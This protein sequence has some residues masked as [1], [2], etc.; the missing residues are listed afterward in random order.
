MLD[1][2]FNKTILILEDN[3]RVVSML[4]DKLYKLEGEQPYELSV[5]VL[6]NHLQVENYINNNPG[7]DFD[8][9]LLDR[10]CKLGGSFHVLDIE[11]FGGKKIISISSVLEY[12][13]QAQSRGVSTAVLKDLANIKDFTDSVVKEVA[14]RI[15]ELPS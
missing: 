11:R 10:D 8:I 6:T 1:M 3:L 4:L 12:N 9:A 2:Y 14:S 13:Q 15:R 5:L 7:A